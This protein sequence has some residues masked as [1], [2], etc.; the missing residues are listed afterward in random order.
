MKFQPIVPMIWTRELEATVSFYCEILG[1]HLG[2]YSEEWGWAA[3][4]KDEC[5]IM[6]ARPNE[7]TPF[8]RPYFSGTF[9]IKTDDVETLWHQIKDKVKVAYDMEDFD[10]GMREFAIY[11]NNSY[12]LQFGQDISRES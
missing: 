7:S 6:I 4:S 9:Y 3:I 8:E 1:F 5:E 12:M 2:N 10:W 11:D